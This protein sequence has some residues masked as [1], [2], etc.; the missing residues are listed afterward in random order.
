MRIFPRSEFYALPIKERLRALAWAA[1]LAP[2]SHNTQPW[3]F[4]LGENW[5]DVWGDT[6]RALTYSDA[7][8]RQLFISLGAA[9]ENLR[10][11]A[12]H[13]GLVPEVAYFPEP[14]EPF[15][16]ARL[17]FNSWEPQ[18]IQES[19]GHLAH[20]ITERKAN[21]GPFHS[22][23]PEPAILNMLINHATTGVTVHLW[24]GDEERAKIRE[25]VGD[26]TE[27]AFHDKNFARELGQ[28]IKPSLARYRDGMPGYNIGVPWLA[29]FVV[30]LAMRYL[31]V[32][33]AQRAMTE[34]WLRTA[35]LMLMLA[36]PKD[37]S[38]D[39]VNAGEVLERIWLRATQLGLSV[40]PLAAAVQIGEHYRRFGELLGNGARPQVFAR[41]GYPKQDW[42]GAPR[43]RLEDVCRE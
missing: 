34:E 1:S 3:F 5:I 32:S 19:E 7:N 15:W 22:H 12:D 2:S 25:I 29:S 43:R 17:V 24:S 18:T 30:P 23:L 9:L 6:E 13:Y 36:T 20:M 33:K 21:R 35:P 16:V 38:S 37:E 39:W 31:P 4:R 28:W 27:E 8:H 14:N 42:R 26:A 41:M 40:A 11:V 10:T